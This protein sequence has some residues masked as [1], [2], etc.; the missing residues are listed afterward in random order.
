MEKT[1]N[2]QKQNMNNRAR[3]YQPI[4][5]NEAFPMDTNCKNRS[6]L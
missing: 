2:L 6:L 4:S 5:D 3:H 1:Y